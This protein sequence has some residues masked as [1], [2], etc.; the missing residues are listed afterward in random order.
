MASGSRWYP[1]P[2]FPDLPTLLISPRFSSS[3]YTLHVTDLAN[4]WVETLDRRGILLRSLQE[5]T[6]IDLSDGDPNQWSVFLSK[7]NAAFDPTEPDHHDTSLTLSASPDE[8]TQDGL[9]L[10]VTCVLPEPLK[11]LKWPVYLAKCQPVELASELVLP[12]IQAHHARTR[13][14]EDLIARLK[15]KD[16]IITKLADK[17][18][19]LGTG[20]EYVFNALSGKRKTTRAM[21]EE[22]VKGLA[23]FDERDWRSKVNADREIPKDVPT[24]IREVFAESDSHYD[25]EAELSASS[26]LNDW[27]TKIG[28]S[29]HTAVKPRKKDIPARPQMEPPQEDKASLGGDDDDFQV[30]ATPPHLQSKR[31]QQGR[32]TVV[33]DT[34]ENDGD[35]NDSPVVIPDSVPIASQEKSRFRIGAIGGGRKA[36]QES[37]AS[38]SSFTVP[39]DE[40]E[41][42]SESDKESVQREPPKR[43][44]SRLGT[45]GNS[46]K[47]SSPPAK[48]SSPVSTPVNDD[49]DETPS[50]SDSDKDESSKPCT[51]SKP[52]PTPQRKGGLGR[53]GGRSRDTPTPSEESKETTSVENAKVA[54]PGKPKGQRIGAIGKRYGTDAKRQRSKSPPK[55]E[56]AESEEQKAARKRS[57]LA[58][59]LEQKATA[60]AKKKRK[61]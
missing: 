15:E 45:I 14:N 18:D 49:G 17:L 26:Q 55:I 2:A 22:K 42:A 32:T 23:V 39:A 46:R 28:T 6:S 7:L 60:P 19:A 47:L 25:A 13:E 33:N 53:I 51:P 20:L 38:Q 52:I 41:T 43:P 59:E 48:S 3:S 54:S 11:P 35:D 21:A 30:Q 10:N 16:A 36:N 58:K 56:E 37:S 27:W 12:L 5:N 50:G 31:K 29:P 40:D 8:A 9:I 44:N 61:F 34:T 24:L 57:E 4:I 1:L